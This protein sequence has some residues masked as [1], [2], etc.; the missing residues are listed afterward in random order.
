MLIS[1]MVDVLNFIDG[2]IINNNPHSFY[3]S[4][5]NQIHNYFLDLEDIDFKKRKKIL[6]HCNELL[7]KLFDHNNDD[8]QDYWIGLREMIVQ[9]DGLKELDEDIEIN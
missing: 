4:Y 8:V 3:I 7:A 1:K 5:I 6:T 9:E 2:G